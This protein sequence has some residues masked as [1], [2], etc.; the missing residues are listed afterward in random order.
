MAQHGAQGKWKEGEASSQFS[1]KAS[2]IPL[3]PSS[4]GSKTAN[5]FHRT[6]LLHTWNLTRN[7]EPKPETWR[8]H[9]LNACDHREFSTPQHHRLHLEDSGK[10]QSTGLDFNWYKKMRL[11]LPPFATCHKEFKRA[12]RHK[13]HIYIYNSHRFNHKVRAAHLVRKRNCECSSLAGHRLQWSLAP[14]CP[15]CYWFAFF[16][17]STPLPPT[18]PPLTS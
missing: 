8:P 18:H 4:D 13:I 7:K 5:W 6:Q 16:Y 14:L 17:A 10:L 1:H 15:H 3:P 9:L 11:S 12:H 2:D